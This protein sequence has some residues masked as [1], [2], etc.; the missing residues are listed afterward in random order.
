MCSGSR[1]KNIETDPE[2]NRTNL[3]TKNE[4]DNQ[5]I[6]SIATTRNESDSVEIFAE[7]RFA[8]VRNSNLKL[9]GRHGP[10]P[11]RGDRNKP[12]NSIDGK[13]GFRIANRTSW[14][15]A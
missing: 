1:N 4:F 2:R 7:R 14:G 15:G 13:L 3:I 11:N 5:A 8:P 6:N 10:S 12:G 9:Y